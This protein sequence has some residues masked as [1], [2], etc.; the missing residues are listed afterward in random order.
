MYTY[1]LAR[2]LYC[3]PFNSH[4]NMPF[5]ES[6]QLFIAQKM[7]SICVCVCVFGAVKE[8]QKRARSSVIERFTRE[9]E[10]V[11]LGIWGLVCE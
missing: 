1:A 7:K 6:R 10:L 3:F 8:K 9:N 5:V 4:K 2:Y 11:I